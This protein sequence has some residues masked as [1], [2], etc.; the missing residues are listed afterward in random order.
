MCCSNILCAAAEQDNC[1]FYHSPMVAQVNFRQMGSQT[2][3]KFVTICWESLFTL[4]EMRRHPPVKKVVNGVSWGFK[5]V[6]SVQKS[7]TR[8]LSGLVLP[9]PKATAL[10]SQVSC[11]RP[12][13]ISLGTSIL[14]AHAICKPETTLKKWSSLGTIWAPKYITSWTHSCKKLKNRLGKS[15][16]IEI[17]SFWAKIG[18]CCILPICT[19]IFASLPFPH[20]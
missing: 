14:E 10:R 5:N 19:V 7:G 2:L 17:W 20:N 16:F 6:S 8:N 15:D 1:P 13:V 12:P 18:G 11:L 3:V 9:L 4:S